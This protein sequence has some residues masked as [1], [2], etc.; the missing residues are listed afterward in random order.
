M[1]EKLSL[2]MLALGAAMV[3]IGLLWLLIV[4]FRCGFIKRAL[5]PLLVVLVGA[6]VAI[7]I[8]VYN[9]L[10]PTP[11]QTTAQ[12]FGDSITITGANKDQLGLVFGH[13]GWKTIQAAKAK[14]A[15]ALTD[16]ELAGLDGMNELQF[17][18]LNDQPVTDTTLERLVKLPK[19]TKLY[20]ARSRVTP[21]GIKQFVLENKNPDFKV[22]ELDI[23]GIDVPSRA[24]RDWKNADKTRK[25]NQ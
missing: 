3:V 12:V 4:A 17:L 13:K 1:L 19:L 22:N 11:I 18:D 24:V 23:S 21:D 2:A 15:P 7:A 9:R 25:V 20:I 10:Y 14:D 16:E 6:G 5:L 8:P